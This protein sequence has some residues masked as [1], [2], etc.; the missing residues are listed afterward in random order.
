MAYEPTQW[1]DHIVDPITG[2]V[3]QQGTPVNAKHLNNMEQGIVEAH[4]ASETA[5]GRTD[6]LTLDEL[7]MRMQYEFDGHARTYGVASNMYWITFRDINDINL[8]AGYFDPA[9]HKL[10][11][12]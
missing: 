8:V 4:D 9:N 1:V 3:I 7:D 6:S 10:I 2:E 5:L 12:P 11:L